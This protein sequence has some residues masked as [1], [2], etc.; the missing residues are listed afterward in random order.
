M[1]AKPEPVKTQPVKLAIGFHS[2]ESEDVD[3]DA[4]LEGENLAIDKKTAAS[5]E[6]KPRA[7]ANCNCGR[8]DKEQ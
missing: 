7:C 2:I 1:R 8:K 3:E 5:C 6:T 4:L